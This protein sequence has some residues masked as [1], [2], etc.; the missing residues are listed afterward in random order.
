MQRLADQV[1]PRE[2]LNDVYV[3]HFPVLR[4]CACAAIC[5]AFDLRRMLGM[6][7]SQHLLL[8]KETVFVLLSL[9]VEAGIVIWIPAMGR[10]SRRCRD[11]HDSF[12]ESAQTAAARNEFPNVIALVWIC[13]T[14]P[15]EADAL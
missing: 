7:R 15:V 6:G 5:L 10:S 11:A 3:T 14:I 9:G 4:A 1:A 2:G 13:V 12:I 8:T